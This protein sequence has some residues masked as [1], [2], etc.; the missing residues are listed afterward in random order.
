MMLALSVLMIGLTASQPR[1]TCVAIDG[2]WECSRDGEPLRTAEGAAS[3]AE[4]L[5]QAAALSR[6][7]RPPAEPAPAVLRGPTADAVPLGFAPLP[8]ATADT[9][10]AS[11]EAVVRA[12][13]AEAVVRADESASGEAAAVSKAAPTV[14]VSVPEAPRAPLPTG[15]YTVQLIAGANRSSLA[16]LIALARDAGVPT[17]VIESERN[18]APWYQLVSG[19]YPDAAAARAAL[20]TLPAALVRSGAFIR[21]L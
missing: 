11:A 8:A 18:G 3:S 7:V 12:E 20:E 15:G 17:E 13:S 10:P 19:R 4:L 6:P 1:Y 14:P 5:R 9:S 2:R 16:P 21:A